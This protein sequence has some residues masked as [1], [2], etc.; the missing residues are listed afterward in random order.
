MIQT[1]HYYL[2]GLVIM[3]GGDLICI[4]PIGEGG[5]WSK[6]VDATIINSMLWRFIAVLHIM[7]HMRPILS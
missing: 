2:L 6:T 4:L 3:F 5:L 1:Q 7:V